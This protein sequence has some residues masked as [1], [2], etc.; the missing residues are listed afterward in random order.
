MAG[1]SP[2]YN[3]RFEAQAKGFAVGDNNIIYNYF[4]YRE[5]VRAAPVDAADDNLPCPYR[6][7][8]HFTPNDSE[9]FFG[10]DVFVEKLFQATQNRNFIPVLG[11]SGSGKSSVVLAGL[12]PKLETDGHWKFTHFRC[13]SDPFH[14]LALALV[15]LYT[16]ELDDTDQIAQARKLASYLSDTTVPLSDVFARIQQ[17]NFNNTLVL[18]SSVGG[19]KLW[20]FDFDNLIVRGCDWVR[21]YLEN[22]P[23]VDEKDRSLCDGID[24]YS[25]TKIES[26]K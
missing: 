7:L 25:R 18:I 3:P 8:Y 10:R 19:G 12:V 20:N 22:N 13:G 16:P 23:S 1:D 2:K 21:G 11:A 26:V 24:T 9:F 14:A 4:G 15:P 17:N 5:E 6:G